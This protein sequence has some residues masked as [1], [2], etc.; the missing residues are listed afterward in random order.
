MNDR[1]PLL[2]RAYTD[3]DGMRL[4]WVEEVAARARIKVS[5]VKKYQTDARLHRRDH[6][7]KPGDLPAAVRKV[8]RVK[9]KA[10]GELVKVHSALWRE[11]KIMAWIAARPYG[12]ANQ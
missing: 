6:K 3:T 7:P 1:S 8:W 4:L 11:D 9:L 5:T 10:D 2:D 12:R